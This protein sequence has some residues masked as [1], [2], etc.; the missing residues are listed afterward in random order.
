MFFF[1][2]FD[3]FKAGN[4][5]VVTTSFCLVFQKDTC[6]VYVHLNMKIVLIRS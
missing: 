6:G 4:D 2:L 3:I 1:F 5:N